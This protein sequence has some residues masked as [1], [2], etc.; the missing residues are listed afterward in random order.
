MADYGVVD[1]IVAELIAKDNG[2]VATFERASAAHE[3][4]GKTVGAL[5]TQNFD[6]AAEGQKYKV[7][8]DAI[9]KAEENSTA[10]I[11]KARKAR[12]AS[13]E[14]TATQE[15][16]AA[17][18]GADAA[19]AQAARLEAQLTAAGQK[20]YYAQGPAIF[21]AKAKE[22][23]AQAKVANEALAK[24]AAAT[25][26]VARRPIEIVEPGS[27]PGLRPSTSGRI[28]ATVDRESFRPVAGPNLEADGAVAAEAEINGSLLEQ[29]RLRAGLLGASKE[30]RVIIR[31][32]LA[33]MRTYNDLLRTGLS[34]EAA[35]VE[36]E[37]I[38]LARGKA[39][40]EQAAKQALASNG[41][42]GAGKDIARFAEGAGLGRSFGSGATVAGIAVA[43]GVG[44]AAAA[45]KDATDYARALT[46]LAHDAGLSTSALQ[47]YQAAATQAGVSQTQFT[48]ALDQLSTNLGRARTGSQEQA[49]VFAALGID[50]KNAS[51][52]GD[53]LPTLIERISSIQDQAKRA[54]VETALFG[55]AG[56]KLDSVLSG[57]N[58]KIS[59]LAKA[60]EDTG[61]ILSQSDI[62]DLNKTA[63][64]LAQVKAQLQVDIARV[65]AGNADAINSLAAS[66]ANLVN[67]IPAAVNGLA[68][69]G[70][71]LAYVHGLARAG[72]GA[73]LNDPEAIAGG[74]AETA[75]AQADIDR[76]NHS[77]GVD[78]QDARIKAGLSG[79][80]ARDPFLQGIHNPTVQG[81][82][83][84][85]KLLDNLGTPKGRKGKSADQLAKEAEERDKRFNDELATAHA[86]QLKAANELVIG[87]EA[88]YAVQ[89]EAIKAESAKKDADYRAQEKLKQI[90]AGR[91]AELIAANDAATAE[92]LKVLALHR[93]VDAYNAQADAALSEIDYQKQIL[94]AQGAFAETS[95]QRLDLANK[96]IALDEE[97]ARQKAIGTIFSPDPNVTDAQR[98]AAGADL[99]NSGSIAQAQR[100]AAGRE[101]E[102]PGQ[103]Y[104]R[105]LKSTSDTVQTAEVS[106]LQ[107]FNSELDKSVE[108]ALHLHGIFGQI[109]GDLIDMAIK[110]ALIAPLAGALF[111][112]GAGSGGGAG[113]GLSGILGLIG[114]VGGLFGGGI[115]GAG[116]ALAGDAGGLFADASLPGI[117]AGSLLG[118]FHFA[119]GG[120]YRIGG[121]PGVD[122]NPISINGQ[123][124]GNVS[125]G[126]VLTVGPNV[127]AANARV[128]SPTNAGPPIIVQQNF[129][130]KNA[131]MTPDLVREMDA[132]SQFHA[133][134][135]RD[136][137]IRISTGQAPQAVAYRQ[138]YRGD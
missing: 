96:Q 37:A 94:S 79:A 91:A 99:R 16:A 117:D 69:I 123:K 78:A 28:G 31:E 92:K 50:I 105:S 133:A 113:G 60:L 122:K 89:Q 17:K 65:V 107:S 63:D 115:P 95:K 64:K 129:D 135:G 124:V 41:S 125:Q 128:N 90:D 49:K 53:L 73:I 126:E 24:V 77:A 57:G 1:Q 76:R 136:D 58:Q 132:R 15:A 85:S 80:D 111:P 71:R 82:G 26:V 4:F 109:V 75:N 47:V 116:S 7:G 118:G 55:E 62:Q 121:N 10:R 40:T 87:A 88:Q 70:D 52:A 48:S 74:A 72:L 56:A 6:L 104:A 101:N 114:K 66:F 9:A 103:A 23:A 59:D 61:A 127:Q 100:A 97:A 68:K 93:Q 3:K 83:V 44:V 27:N 29:I 46:D 32:Q 25:P 102:S 112:G 22:F 18:K 110:Q 12:V 67:S 84:N 2:Y 98:T 134:Q 54:R 20:R 43:A 51:T 86:E 13:A 14:Q 138:R 137:A 36:L 81:G 19:I 42:T 130:Y 38:R 11:T 120:S 8:A 21:E 33:D 5:K 45:I 106:A 39:L 108:K 34:E 35:I 131:V 30:D 119:N